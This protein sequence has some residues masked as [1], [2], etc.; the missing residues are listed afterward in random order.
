MSMVTRNKCGWFFIRVVWNSSSKNNGDDSPYNYVAT[1][2]YGA[3]VNSQIIGR[4]N[5]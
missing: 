4:P 1:T 2:Y 5:M 3:V